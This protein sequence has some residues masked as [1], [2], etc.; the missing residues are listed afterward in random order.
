VGGSLTIDEP[1]SLCR[2][3]QGKRR[4]GEIRGGEFH[5]ERL[6][7][8]VLAG[9]SLFLVPQDDNIARFSVY[10]T[11][12]TDDG[13]YVEWKFNQRSGETVELGKQDHALPSWPTDFYSMIRGIKPFLI[14]R[15]KPKKNRLPPLQ[16]SQGTEPLMKPLISHLFE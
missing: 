9:G 4:S 10:Y 7:G 14:L 13:I 3:H 6:Q 11:L 12:M 15:T 1:Q 5:G 16:K 2:P 8:R